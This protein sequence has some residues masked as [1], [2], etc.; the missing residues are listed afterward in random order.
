MPEATLLNTRPAAQA[1]ALA[2]LLEKAGFENLFC[3]AI[4]IERLDNPAPS[5]ADF[6]YVF[7]VSTNS[8]KA[9]ADTWQKQLNL[10][11]FVPEQTT[12]FAI[13]KATEKALK[14]LGIEA[15]TPNQKYDTETLIAEL[16]E[17]YFKD[18][19]CLIVKGEGGLPDLSAA[20]KKQGAKVTEWLGYRR[21]AAS[22]C[23]ESWQGFRQANH[24]VL[25]ASS[26]ESWQS[27]I[28]QMPASEKS[29]LWQQDLI[30]FSERIA[31]AIRSQGWTGRIKVVDI[32]SNEGVVETLKRLS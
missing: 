5:L 9:L 3:P 22:F 16:P 1:E 15:K 11:L 13:G 30:A 7:F 20:L 27:L 28:G 32:Q 31:D 8:V 23:N 4:R 26:L 18:A 17:A 24:P 25:L 12:C 21:V 6:Q 14:K 29:W 19:A 2:E 10:P